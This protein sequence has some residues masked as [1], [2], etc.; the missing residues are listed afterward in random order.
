MNDF[1]L[2]SSLIILGT[3][4]VGLVRVMRGPYQADRIIA[5]QLFAT[6]GV[7]WILLVSVAVD[8][9]AFIDV[10]LVFALLAAVTAVAF[11]RRAWTVEQK[12]GQ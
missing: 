11:V 10:A 7:A 9:I 8:T 3:I 2:V 5:A 4:T 6:A 12:E 1:L